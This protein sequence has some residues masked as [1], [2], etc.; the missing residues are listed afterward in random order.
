MSHPRSA[1][2]YES[3]IPGARASHLLVLTEDDWNAQMQDSVIAPLY[4]ATLAPSKVVVPVGEDLVALCTRVQSVPHDFVGNAVG[5]CPPDAWVRVRVGVR[6][7]LDIDRRSKRAPAPDPVTEREH[8]WPRQRAI[9]FA[10]NPHIGPRDKLYAVISDDDWNSAHATRY[11]AAVR[12]TSRTKERRLR[13]E[14]AVAGSW[15]VTGDLY[16]IAHARFEQTPPRGDY[17]RRMTPEESAAVAD[18]QKIALNRR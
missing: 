2:I 16:S 6:V 12:L 7:Y 13:W 17:P 4:R 8:W 14:V 9:H 5:R 15:I 3:A 10:E 18:R 11:A 1:R